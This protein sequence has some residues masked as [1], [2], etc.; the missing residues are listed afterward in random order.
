MSG[1]GLAWRTIG[2]VVLL[3]AAF[4]AQRVFVTLAVGGDHPAV[5]ELLP[6]LMSLVATAW[7]L[8]TRGRVLLPFASRGFVMVW[9]P[10]LALT[11]LLPILGVAGGGYSVRILAAIQIPIFAL[12]AMVLGAGV[13]SVTR[14]ALAGWGIP[15][16]VAI[17]VV[18]GYAVLQQL[19]VGHVLANGPWTSLLSWDISTQQTYGADVIL[20]RSSA[21]YV[22]PNILGATAGTTLL[23]GLFAAAGWVR[24]AIVFA[25]LEALLVSQSRGAT[26]A[27]VA[28][29]GVLAVLAWRRHEQVRVR[30]LLPYAG[31]AAL[32]LA[33]WVFLVV[34]GTPADTFIERVGQGVG[35]VTGGSD[36][37]LSGR[38]QFWWDGLTLLAS[39]PLGTWGPPER[40]LGTAV[41][42]DWVRAL[43]QGSLLYAFTLGC[44]LFGGAFTPSSDRQVQRLLVAVSVFVAVA[45]L[46]QLPLAYPGAVLYWA[47]V[48]AA[49]AGWSTKGT[50]DGGASA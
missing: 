20:G 40:L 12:G 26:A 9:G 8:R 15:L 42:S 1:M 35:V 16:L 47:V 13:R 27:L 28:S 11:I 34:A 7:I 25:S 10:Y 23:F 5:I 6:I 29:L 44:A 22:N 37:N 41:D 18:A 38:L 33:C 32:A 50:R 19:I 3:A 46:T 39:H 49:V 17:S 4:F 45:A 31:I 21:F 24:Y 43:L 36:P 30:D 14:E 48:G 2:V